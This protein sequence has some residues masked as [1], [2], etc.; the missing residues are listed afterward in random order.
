VSVERPATV[1]YGSPPDQSPVVGLI[2]R[3][4]DLWLRVI[5]IRRLP[6]DHSQDL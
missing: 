3:L 6:A 2:S 4:H 1:L 5:E